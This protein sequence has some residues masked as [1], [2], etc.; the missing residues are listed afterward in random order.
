MGTRYTCLVC[1]DFDLCEVCEED[2]EEVGEE[3]EHAL[4]Q[5]LTPA[6][7]LKLSASKDSEKKPHD[8][9]ED[10]IVEKASLKQSA[11]PDLEEDP[12]ELEKLG[13]LMQRV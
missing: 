4:L 13:D 8:K 5:V 9:V 6:D 12:Y 10:K 1:K 11:Y 7:A 3:H 2:A